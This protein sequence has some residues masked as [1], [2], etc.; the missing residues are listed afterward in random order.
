M[1]DAAKG[2]AP[3]TTPDTTPA[4]VAGTHEEAAPIEF[5]VAPTTSNEFNTTRLRLIPV[6]CFRVDDIRFAFDSSFVTAGVNEKDDIRA[7]LKLLVDLLKQHP[8][9]PLSLF[10][11]ADPVGND[12]YNKLLSG[13]RATVIYALLISGTDPDTAVSLWQRV[14]KEENWGARERQT[15]QIITGL[16]AGTP[17]GTL[18]KAYMQKLLPP[19]LRLGKQDFLAQG[20]DSRGK[21]DYQGCS[22]F[23]PVLIFSS[24]KNTQFE[25]QT[26]K[27]A[28]NDANAPNRRVMVLLFRK[29]SKVDPAKWPCPR[30]TEGVA[31]CRK[32]FW[33]DGERRRSTRLPDQDRKFDDLKDTFA[34]RFYQR[35]S[36]NSPCEQSLA[37]VRIRLF[38]RQA[39]PL[40][41]A[42]CVITEEGKAPRADRASG[43]VPNPPPGSTPPGSNPPGSTPPGGNPPGSSPPGAAPDSQDAFVVL[44]VTRFPATVNVKWSRP[45][46]GDGPNS[47]PPRTDEKFEFEMD[48]AVDIPEANQEAASLT[49]LKNLGYVQSPNQSDNIRAFQTDYKPRFSDIQIDGTL[50]PPT[51]NAIKTVHDACD[52]VVKGRP[53]TP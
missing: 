40:P 5:L 8:G 48:V 13:R 29:G 6:A 31:G 15:M 50:N 16:P 53:S 42:P 10:G 43:L 44:R 27:T 36:T 28:R 32:R 1:S 22:E 49:R 3:G 30:A 39:R 21:G 46:S 51:V 47:P 23:N 20:A 35:I 52:P 4:G 9:S 38:D 17:D 7:E 26:N 2:N 14:S 12:D 25:S 18:F 41:F 33:S 34:C 19:E 37:I 24:K 45:R 11:H